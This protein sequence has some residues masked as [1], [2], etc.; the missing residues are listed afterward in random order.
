MA[1]A[2]AVSFATAVSIA[3]TVT[4]GAILIGAFTVVGVA[5]VRRVIS[6]GIVAM[7]VV[8]VATRTA[9]ATSATVSAVSTRASVATR[10]AVITST[11]GSA[12]AAGPAIATGSTGVTRATVSRVAAIRN[13][14]ATG[15][16]PPVIDVAGR[17]NHRISSAWS[18][19]RITA[20]RAGYSIGLISVAGWI[21][22][23]EGLR[24]DRATAELLALHDLK[25]AVVVHGWIGDSRYALRPKPA[26]LGRDRGA[27]SEEEGCPRQS[28]S[29]QALHVFT[30]ITSQF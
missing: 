18:D 7:A 30:Y 23:A 6:I 20:D 4:G 24:T 5:W 3:A 28:K 10:A 22:S 17:A 12:I 26:V 9:A 21:H 15:G 1:S 2:I 29:V 11:A 25:P 13:S 14:A 16:A 8:A 19:G 27:D